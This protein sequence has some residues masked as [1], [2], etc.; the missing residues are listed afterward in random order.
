DREFV[1]PRPA[2]SGLELDAA[3]S[4]LNSLY[5]LAQRSFRLYTGVAGDLDEREQRI[6]GLLVKSARIVR[7]CLHLG[8]LFVELRQAARP[9]GPVETG[10]AHP[11]LELPS[12]FERWQATWDSVDGRRS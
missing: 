7:G 5:G 8:D 6:A 11:T 1:E 10:P 3:E 4:P 12:T 2:P 9:I